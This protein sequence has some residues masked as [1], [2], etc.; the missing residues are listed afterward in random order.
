MITLDR[1]VDA[2]GARARTRIPAVTLDREVTA[3]TADSRRVIPGSL[4]V[5]V[6]G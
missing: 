3:V 2:L 4:F 1:I 5:A 6:R